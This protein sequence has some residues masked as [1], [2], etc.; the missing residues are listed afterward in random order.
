MAC[1]INA[2]NERTSSLGD[3]NY[4]GYNRSDAKASS[5]KGYL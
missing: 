4:A 5:N 1:S 2:R 3:E